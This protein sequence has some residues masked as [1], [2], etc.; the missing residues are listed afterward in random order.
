M[1][2]GPL[3]VVYTVTPHAG[4]CVGAPYTVTVTVTT[5]PVV[6][7][8][9]ASVCS[10]SPTGVTL[11]TLS[12][13][14]LT[15]TS[16]DITAVVPAGLTGTATTGTGLTTAA[17]ITADAFTNVTNGPLDVVY[18]VTPHAGTCVG[19]PYTV[20][21]TVTP[22]PVVPNVT[23]SVCSASPT[24]V[25]LLT[26]STNG[27]TITSW[28]ITA[29]VPAG[30]TG[31]ATT[32]TGLTTAAAINADAFTNVTNGPLDVV[33]TVTPHAGTCVGAPYTVTVTVTPLPTA[34]PIY[35]N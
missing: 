33:Y 7:N 20:T 18:T 24:G 9:T 5:A 31:T 22:A 19:A 12:T 25:T 27:L 29:V 4:T 28:D 11:L 14:G 35:H 21:V 8:V 13:N 30:L 15:I 10:A 6:P 1:T 16:W 17:A 3:D 32:G 26:L 23:A 34:S 2:N